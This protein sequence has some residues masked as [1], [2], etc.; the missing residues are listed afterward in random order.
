MKQILLFILIVVL[1]YPAS[2]ILPWW[3]GGVICFIIAYVIKPGYFTAFGTSLLA[4]F[5]I[6]YT[7]AFWSDSNFDI[8]VSQLL[9]NLFGKISKDAVLMLTGLTGALP[10]ALSGLLGNWTRAFISLHKKQTL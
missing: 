10:A 7:K 5:V 4:V 6:W 1:V 8:P 2:L 3:I 9:G